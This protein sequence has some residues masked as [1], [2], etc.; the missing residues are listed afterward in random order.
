MMLMEG[1]CIHCSFAECVKITSLALQEVPKSQGSIGQK[2][3]NIWMVDKLN[4]ILVLHWHWSQLQF[5][6]TVYW[7]SKWYSWDTFTTL[8]FHKSF[9][10]PLQFTTCTLSSYTKQT[11]HFTIFKFHVL[12]K[13]WFH[14]LELITRICNKSLNQS[15]CYWSVSQSLFV[16]E[17]NDHKLGVLTLHSPFKQC[18]QMIKLSG[19][20][21]F[22]SASKQCAN[23]Y[24]LQLGLWKCSNTYRD[25]ISKAKNLCQSRTDE[26]DWQVT[27]TTPRIWIR[28]VVTISQ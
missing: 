21:K 11:L 26:M 28:S 20:W 14:V 19:I 1:F 7:L 2:L 27:I 6:L 3:W 23:Q 15:N 5:C 12:K 4:L 16:V 8:M 9:T 18:L 13:I 22:K 17:C 25:V 24:D 10:D